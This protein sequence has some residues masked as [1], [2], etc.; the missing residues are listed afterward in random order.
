MR[1]LC[2]CHI[3]ISS[4]SNL[5][6]TATENSIHQANAIELKANC[7]ATTST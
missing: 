6:C 7:K 3:C 5:L 2:A 4:K 1:M